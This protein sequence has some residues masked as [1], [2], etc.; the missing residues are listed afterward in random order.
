[1]LQLYIGNKNYS[2]WSLR[3]WVAMRQVGIA[4]EEVPVRFDSFDTGSQFK[5]TMA[6]IAPTG[7]VPVLVDEGLAIWDTLAIV[8]Y[9]AERFPRSPGPRPPAQAPCPWARCRPWSA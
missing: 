9:L 5:Q 7:K 2:S 8:E 1:M 6:G 3:P 4:F